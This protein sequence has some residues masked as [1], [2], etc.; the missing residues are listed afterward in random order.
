MSCL[1]RVVRKLPLGGS[2]EYP[3]SVHDV[4]RAGVRVAEAVSARVID[5]SLRIDPKP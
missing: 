1:L 4:A 3:V 5:M 2:A